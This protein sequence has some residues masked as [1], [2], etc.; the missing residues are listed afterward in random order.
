MSHESHALLAGWPDL[1]CVCERAT[2]WALLTIWA[3]TCKQ[4]SNQYRL[5]R[6]SAAGKGRPRPCTSAGVTERIAV[7]P[8][9]L[10]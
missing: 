3:D 10:T 7:E 9:H 1:P 2:D 6:R 8:A 4:A 5:A